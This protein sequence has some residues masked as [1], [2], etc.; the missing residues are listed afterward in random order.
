[1]RARRV[2]AVVAAAAVCACIAAASVLAAQSK[3]SSGLGSQYDVSKAG[4]QTL[5]I[6]WLGNQEIPGIETWMK[7]N[8]ALYEKAHPNIKV[9]TVLE[10]T[11][12]YITQQKTACKSGTG[13]DIWYNWGGNFSLAL[14]WAGCVV[15]NEDALAAADLKPVPATAGTK[16]QGKTWIYPI[17]QRLYPVIYNKDLFKKAGISANK[18]PKTWSQFVA[19]AAKLKKA[20]VQALVTG[21]KDGWGGENLAVAIERQA[22]TEGQ[23]ITDV[24]NNKLSSSWSTWLQKAEQLKP[25]FNNDVNSLT[26]SQGLARFQAGQAAMIFASP[27]WQQ[28]VISMNKAGHHVGIFKVPTYANSPQASKMYEDTPGFQVT[29]FAKDKAL[30]GNFLAFIHSPSRMQALY[31]ETGDIPSDL[32]W[33]TTHYKS[34][35]DALLMQWLKPGFTYYSANYYPT[36]LDVNGNFVVFQGMYGGSG[37]TVA[38][39]LSTY[40]NV[41]SKWHKSQSV[42]LQSYKLWEK[43]YSNK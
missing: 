24:V 23:L 30:A 25:Y 38:K 36:D 37:M 13:P 18:T 41:L 4:N 11:D 8:V 29:K 27:G 26:Y 43:D 1:M 12:T 21:L 28:T 2:F 33:H 9:Q 19:T 16:W 20:G 10:G 22:L 42:E 39:A 6:W 17:E 31:N 5:T 40:Q 15:P 34:P 7:E 35:T 14:A 32:R 3:G